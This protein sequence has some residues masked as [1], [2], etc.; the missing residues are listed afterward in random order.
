[1]PPRPGPG[2]NSYRGKTDVRDPVLSPLYSDLRGLP[3]TLFI[4]SSRDLLL[5]GTTLLH[6]AY[7]RAGNDAQLVVFD[8][9]TP[10]FWNDP[11]LPES[12]E[13]A[14]LMANFFDTHLGK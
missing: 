8:A 3:P 12:K 6:R 14:H 1:M 13:A 11:D 2:A 10:A 5:S 9:L 7:L 4:S